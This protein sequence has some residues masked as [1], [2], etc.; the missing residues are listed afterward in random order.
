MKLDVRARLQELSINRPLQLLTAAGLVA[1]TAAAASPLE[2][3]PRPHA[4]VTAVEQAIRA[5]PTPV[6]QPLK[7]VWEGADVDG[8]GRSDFA[9]PTG[10]EPRT[11]DSYGEGA[12]LASRDGGT[13]RHEGVDYV[14]DAGQEVVAPMSGYVTKI[15]MAYAGDS[16]LKFVEIT[17]P[18]LR[19]AVRT[20][21]VN[22][23]VQVGDS[24]HV[25]Q[26]IGTAHSLQ[27]RYP[28]GMTNHVHLEIIDKGGRR[29][30]ST[31]LITAEYRPAAPPTLANPPVTVA[32][33][34]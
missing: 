21:Y 5:E 4:A 17:N 29:I 26:P 8:D 22:P 9:N 18:A 7:L 15:G 24:V 23:D 30:D 16:T 25:G 1:A 10:K 32:A 14:A 27:K 28:R 34:D 20:F 31:R 11:H 12:F 13:R 3:L 19:Y 6:V 2:V 33:A